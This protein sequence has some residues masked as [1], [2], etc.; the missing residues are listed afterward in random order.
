MIATAEV[1]GGWEARSG[2]AAGGVSRW[3]GSAAPSPFRGQH[4]RS[5]RRAG[6][7]PQRTATIRCEHG[8]RRILLAE[9]EGI[10]ARPLITTLRGGGTRCA[11]SGPSASCAPSCPTSPRAAAPRHH[12][13]HRRPRVPPGDPLHPRL[14]AGR[15]GG[16]RRSRG[17]PSRERAHQLGAAAVVSKPVEETRLGG[18]DRG[19]CRVPVGGPAG[20]IAP[21]V[22]PPCGAALGGWRPQAVRPSRGS[23]HP[24][25]T[26]HTGTQT[27]M[28]RVSAAVRR[29]PGPGPGPRGRAGPSRWSSPPAAGR[30]PPR[31]AR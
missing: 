9:D 13:R 14:P 30:W 27:G 26:S 29:R 21:G 23:P 31:A 15:G 17:H 10:V 12:P 22:R 3:G 8:R 25:P 19:A 24:A 4:S 20:E 16:A 28:R 1:P 6:R 11:G 5:W 18:A 7:P 2:G